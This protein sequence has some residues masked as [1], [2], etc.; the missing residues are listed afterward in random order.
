MSRRTD[1]YQ[2]TYYE[3]DD[4]TDASTEMQRWETLDAQLYALF[5][6]IGN[7]IRTGWN[8]SSESGL[9][10]TISPGSGHVAFVAVKSDDSVTIENL[11]QSTTQYI[12]AEI[13][14]DS[15]WNQTV[16]FSSYS[17]L[18][19]N[20]DIS[21]YLGSVTTDDTSVTS[22]S[23]DDRPVLGFQSLIDQAVENHR[24]IGGTDNPDPI[25]LASEVQGVLN[26]QNVPDLD[27]SKIQ[28]GV[29][30]EDR[31]PKI[32]HVTG[33][34]DQGTL[35]HAQL[36]TFVETLNITDNKKMGEVS[37]VNLLQLILALKHQYPEIDEYLVN[38]VAFIPGISPDDYVDTDNTTAEV[39]YRTFAEGG[40]HTITMTPSSGST[41]YTR[42]WD[43]EDDF[44]DSTRDNVF[45]DG[46]S[47]CLATTTNEETLDN[48][49]DLS[50][51]T[52][53]TEDL[54][55][56]TSLVIELDNSDSVSSGA[57][58]KVSVTDE[59]TEMALVIK[60][61]FDAQDWTDFDFLTFYIRTED[62]EHGDWQ[63]YLTDSVSGIQ[64]SYI[65]MLDRNTPTVNVDT[66]ENG[67][68][69]VR[70]DIR[71]FV[72]SS[73]NQIALFTST[74][75]GWDNSKPFNIN[76]DQFS[77]STGN[78]YKDTGYARV[79]YG[80]DTLVDFWRI[81]WEAIV[82]TD[83]ASTGVV[84]QVRFRNSNTEA[85]LATAEWSDYFTTS[86]T[87]LDIE[88]GTLY[89]YIEIEVYFEPSANNSRTVC[90][91]KLYLDFYIS[92]EDAQFEFDSQADWETGTLF[93]IDTTTDA[94]S[95]QISNTDDIETYYYAAD[96][97]AGQLDSSFSTNFSI[98]GSSL[99]IT[100]NQALNS[101]S[102]SFGYLSSVFRG[103]DGSFW[104]SD[105]TNDRVIKT[106]K[107]G[108][109]VV[110]IYGSNLVEPS[111]FYG[112]EDSGPGSNTSIGTV[113]ESSIS[114]TE[115]KVLHSTYNETEGY[116][117]I[118]FNDN[119]SNVYD[120]SNAVDMSRLYL[121]VGALRFN[122]FDST[123]ELVG[124]SK[125]SYDIWGDLS[126]STGDAVEFANHFRYK[127]NVLKVEL[128]GAD[129][130]ALNSAL[131]NENPSIAV[132]NPFQNYKTSSSSVKVSF[133]IKNVTLGNNSGQHG[134]KLTLDS[135][136]PVTIYDDNYTFTSLSTGDHEV[137]IV[138]VDS[139][140]TE[141]TN[142]E[143]ST[144]LNFS[145]RSSYTDPY[146]SIQYPR[147]NQVYSNDSIVVDFTIE[148][149]PIIPA[150]QHIQYKVDSDPAVDYYSA[151]PITIT[152]LDP[153]KHTLTIFTV[154]ES[155]NKLSYNHGEIGTEFIIGVNLNATLKLY[156][157]N[158]AVSSVNGLSVETSRTNTDVANV[159]FRNIYAPVD[160]Q[161]IPNDTSGLAGSEL[162]ILVAKLRS[163]SFIEGLSGQ[164]NADEVI[165]RAE[166]V[167]RQA[168]GET[169]LTPDE[170]LESI[171]TNKLIFGT[172]Y[173]DGHSV[174][175]LNTKGE[176]LFSNNAAKFAEN[177]ERAKLLLGSVEKI[178]DNEL[179]IGDSLRKRAITVYTDLDTNVPQIIWQ[180]DS[181]K[182]V[183][184]FHIVPQEQIT[185]NIN[186]DSV[187]ESNVFIRQGTTIV[188]KNN[189]SSPVTVYSGTTTLTIF[190]QDPDLTLYGDTFTSAV[191][192]PGDTYEYK[193][194]T[195]GEFDWFAYPD[196]LTGKITVTKQRLSSRDLYYILESDGL[197]SPFTSRLIK[198]DSWGNVQ[199]SFGESLLVQPR[200]VR[201]MFNGNILL[202]T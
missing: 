96:G 151:D 198:V 125:S 144:T 105:L 142:D 116:L 139:T 109:L 29:L 3:Q 103:S 136:T 99:P 45:I 31:I 179:M 42:V 28:T 97:E 167:A 2:L 149:F 35:T 123:T 26:Q 16:V 44:T 147:P 6:V 48:L 169:L 178:G 115:F 187:S 195:E 145:R 9:N 189:S 76:I 64:N 177:S 57:S 24:H 94:G 70:V 119:L 91:Q 186:D 132:G 8:L 120:A 32:D 127:S 162:S 175:Q 80:S 4:L 43:T 90:L 46:N 71:S 202:S 192:D 56:G 130:T 184:D 79:T 138:L 188:W 180:F 181:D 10:V 17:N 63:F 117:Y 36:D 5:D 68:Q 135:G 59:E 1:K 69:E 148:N 108:N 107:Y 191:L 53:V 166:N 83:A 102:T 165:L 160:L 153:G 52:V 67:W 171:S 113:T 193:F 62:V 87:E 185:I 157:D 155:G 65:T 72:R 168:S 82:P 40:Q 85:G 106:D 199:W 100:T 196:I 84:F 92:D 122:L 110:G 15:Y 112:T 75:L 39:D 154:D 34:S 77:L 33:L 172:N 12:Y 18:Q 21:L 78:Y 38:E 104:L 126:T 133:S 14:E 93:N 81:R 152:G 197:E 47:V 60:K 114:V 89:K 194:V 49:S 159:Y 73:I 118:V 143:A 30:S 13:T 98:T 22:I 176:V 74:Q 190:N 86:G 140:S 183:P 51:W 129:K 101:E 25:N 174:V 37:T 200:D 201:P 170:D 41:T 146:L 182:F 23:T 158:G 128:D 58:G 164:D 163:P 61:D 124:V 27:A 20:D 161:V 50:E 173:L 54:S 121:K 11:L 134:I 88:D 111:D 137:D 150:G 66:L 141:L 7:G 19:D 131:S 95:I 55:S 156:I